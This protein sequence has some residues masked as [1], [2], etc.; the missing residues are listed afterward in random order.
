MKRSAW[1]CLLLVANTG[2]TAPRKAYRYNGVG[3]LEEVRDVTSDVS[4][5]GAIGRACTAGQVCCDGSCCSGTCNNGACCPL[6]SCAAWQVC[7]QTANSCGNSSS[8]MPGCSAGQRCA[9]SSCFEDRMNGY[10]ARTENAS[11]DLVLVAGNRWEMEVTG[12]FVS[13]KGAYATA[14]AFALSPRA[15]AAQST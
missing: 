7:G 9:A 6:V 3:A 13:S 8:C 10:I 2:A 4:N 12:S 15:R 11:N 14:M 1:L 5:C